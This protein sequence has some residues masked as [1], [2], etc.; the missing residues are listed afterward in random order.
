MIG[1][2][3]DRDVDEDLELPPEL[4]EA[5]GKPAFVMTDEGVGDGVLQVFPELLRP[6]WRDEDD[7]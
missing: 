4:A 5:H 3:G 6:R 2:N 1:P 7:R